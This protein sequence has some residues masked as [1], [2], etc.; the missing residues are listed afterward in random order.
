MM[1]KKIKINFRSHEYMAKDH[2]LSLYQW[3]DYVK[4][5]YEGYGYDYKF[6]GI[7]DMQISIEKTKPS[8][9]SYTEI[10]LCLRDKTK[11]FLN[12]RSSM[13]NCLRLCITAASYPVTKKAS[14][15]NKYI[16]HLVEE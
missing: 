6:I 13:Y 5:M 12:I 4:E 9:G 1:K 3:L 2:R 8:I 16:D 11:A 10:P 15:E 7:T 14:R